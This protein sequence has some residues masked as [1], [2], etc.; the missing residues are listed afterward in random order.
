MKISTRLIIGLSLKFFLILTIICAV[1]YQA[2]LSQQKLT[3]I[4]KISN[5]RIKLANDMVDTARERAIAVRDI[6]LSKYNN[7]SEASIKEIMNHASIL[8]KEYYGYIATSKK[9]GQHGND[10]IQMLS[11]LKKIEASGALAL[12]LQDQAIKLA[13]MGKLREANNFI[14]KIAYPSVRRWIQQMDIFVI[15]NDKDT[16]SHFAEAEKDMSFSF[17]IMLILGIVA[18]AFSLLIAYVLTLSITEPLNLCADLAQKVANGNLHVDLSD[19]EQRRD[20][21]GQLMRMLNKMVAALVEHRKQEQQQDWLKTGIA[22]LNNVMAG[23]PDTATLT[24]KVISEIANYLDVPMGAI[25]LIQSPSN[26]ITS[27]NTA[28]NTASLALAGS[29]AYSDSNGSKQKTDNKNENT[30]KASKVF[31]LGEGLVGQAALEKKQI[32]LKNVP[33]DYIKITS[34]LGEMIPRFICVTPF[35]HENQVKG[36]LEIAAL[37]EMNNQQMEY[38]EQAMPILALAIESAESRLKL[39]IS[40]EESRTI[41]S[42]LQVQQEELESTNE[43]LQ[44]QT[45]ALKLS[46]EK[47]KVQRE[48]LKVINEELEK[49]NI[50]LDQQKT[51]LARA[52][53][54]KT[55]FLSNMSHE[56]RTPLNSLLL[57][58]RSLSE[59]K[60]GN[61][62]TEQ[63]ECAK[64]IY[65]SG[66]DL[67]NLIN[68]ILDLSKIEAGRM[69]LQISTFQISE[70]A[71]GINSF[72]KPM[73]IHKDLS[74][75]V[76]VEQN[77]PIEI[78]S[79]RKRIEQLIRNLISNAIKFTDSGGVT[80]TFTRPSLNTSLSKSGLSLQQC[81]A[82]IVSD[83]GIGISLENQKIIFEAFTQV[84]GGNT[85]TYGGT[86][87]GLSISRELASLLCGEIQ[88]NSELGR[89]STF[90]LYLPL[91]IYPTALYERHEIPEMPKSPTNVQQKTAIIQQHVD[92][93]RDVL[94]KN[95]KVILIIEDDL[96]FAKSLY[97]KCQEKK[98]KSLIALTGEDGLELA[99]KYLPSAILLDIQLPKMDGW[100]VL[101]SLKGNT[102][103]RHIPVHVISVEK[104]S[105]YALK[106]G[107][108]G[109]AAKP[110]NQHDLE[111]TFR[112]LEEVAPGKTKRVLVVEDN[113]IIRQQTV[114]LIQDNDVIVDE[115]EIGEQAFELLSLYDYDCV[116]LDIGLP[117][118]NGN[119]L[120]T[121]LEREVV[122]LPP[123]IIYTVQDVTHEQEEK[124]LN[125]AK[126]IVIKDVR[127][128]ER[129]LD[130][131]S[132]F[133]HRVVEKMPEGKKQIILNLY[134]RDALLRDKNIILAD[135]DMRT[136]FAISR[137]LSDHGMTTFKAENGERA[138]QMLNEHPNVDIV[139]MDIMMPIMD[140]LETIKRIRAQERF[141]NLP[142]IALTAK[143]MAEDRD[144]CLAAGANDY[145]QKPLD[146]ERLISMM[147]IWLYR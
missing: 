99:T 83:T 120:L 6:L 122:K 145:L 56:L 51:E 21:F 126:S 137:F 69:D 44:E 13:S 35:I 101:D 10:D 16:A 95:D 109:H 31:Y 15:Y 53:K 127:S 117:D 72:F 88:V 77:A 121:K 25:Y 41:A 102:N 111:E 132:L 1:L 29:Y 90:S 66:N 33:S 124:L 14:I 97:K 80:V 4:E 133:L 84:D 37:S 58:A 81:L 34:G 147:R 8:K 129:L 100:S 57:L 118:M 140:G 93:D 48:E 55:E 87:L 107:A 86:G 22:R 19:G 39:A 116:V 91:E 61:L 43:E 139:L 27:A 106:R 135:D 131:V 110:I 11:L 82:I 134:D 65:S 9:L 64:I 128:Q 108:I 20:E 76:V 96:N 7:E 60:E 38:L 74:L 89:G 75:Q 54:Y 115:A 79:D 24:Y 68:E 114:K 40:F 78:K 23:N 46:E 12:P 138:L 42:E 144:K 136:T 119:E 5:V 146:Q 50:L 92:D 2:H 26:K 18:L 143:A 45:M 98:F 47:L 94:K 63:I 85:R 59:N 142:I 36:V 125:Y 113:S 52:S 71:E 30:Y 62:I 105:N 103:T 141:I 123:I 17:I 112:K 130:E 3:D 67:L 73:A 28:T 70:L 49:K 32:L 104:A